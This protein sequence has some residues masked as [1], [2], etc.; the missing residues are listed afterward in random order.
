M[1]IN[2]CDGIGFFDNNEMRTAT[3]FGAT[4]SCQFK[5]VNDM[6]KLRKFPRVA[7]WNMIR[8]GRLNVSRTDVESH[9]EEWDIF[10]AKS[11]FQTAGIQI[12][13]GDLIGYHRKY[14]SN[15][16]NASL[17]FRHLQKLPN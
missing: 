12:K 8:D 7:S 5:T 6:D 3:V 4:A 15:A 13:M 14:R 10:V 9:I 2:K 17:A 1:M 16:F 11:D